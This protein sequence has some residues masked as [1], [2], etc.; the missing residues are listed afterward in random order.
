MPTE[1][2]EEEDLDAADV[3]R[4]PV[5]FVIFCWWK[6]IIH[7]VNWCLLLRRRSR[8]AICGYEIFFDDHHQRFTA[9]TERSNS[10]YQSLYRL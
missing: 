9:M 2:G 5:M 7:M 6:K 4:R 10:W 3:R 1:E 8:R